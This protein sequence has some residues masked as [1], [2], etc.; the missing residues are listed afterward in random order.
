MTKFLTKAALAATVA[1]GL[2]ARAG[3]RGRRR[4]ADFTAN[5]RIVKPAD[6]DQ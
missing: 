4:Q 6:A 3:V 1:T 2:F 5:A